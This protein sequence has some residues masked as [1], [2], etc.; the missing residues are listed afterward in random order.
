LY[1]TSMRFKMVEG[2]KAKLPL[3]LAL[4]NHVSAE[5]LSPLKVT[6]F[7][8]RGKLHSTHRL[9]NTTRPTNAPVNSATF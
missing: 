8:G 2:P 7:F 1:R 4:S 6:P 5:M 3:C 9:I